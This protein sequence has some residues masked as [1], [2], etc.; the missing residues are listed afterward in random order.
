[1]DG[2]IGWVIALAVII[3]GLV[4][5]YFWGKKLQQRYAEQQEMINQHKQ[6]V[7]LFILDK[8]K[9]KIDNLKL[10]KQVKEQVPKRQKNKKM[11]VVIAKIG[12][13]IQ[14]F[15]CDE[16]MYDLIPVKKQIKAEVAGI[17]LVNILSGKLPQTKK[18][19]FKE[20]LIKKTR[21]LNKMN[22]ENK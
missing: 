19:S 5:L 8:K 17:M 2:W 9:D 4:G 3:A 13:Q 22:T 11:P 20:K 14:T 21:E 18:P 12:P 6:A 7:Q 10:P 15:L 16:T 1:M